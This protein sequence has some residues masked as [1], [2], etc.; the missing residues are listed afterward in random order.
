MLRGRFGDSTGS[1]YIQGSLGLVASG[2]ITNISFFVDT[3]ADS[4]T[5]MP[6]DAR[7]L[8]IDFGALRHPDIITAAGGDVACFR[9]NAVVTFHDSGLDQVFVYD[10]SLVIIPPGHGTEDIPSLLG[11]DI[12]KHWGML[13]DYTRR[14][15]SFTV[16][17]A[18][19]THD[20]P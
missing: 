19:R 14:R 17:S 10:V 16:R 5:L 18:D 12:L 7:H 1:P 15:I 4:T 11:R 3:G 13:W 6:N 2:D 8:G 9:E 20:L